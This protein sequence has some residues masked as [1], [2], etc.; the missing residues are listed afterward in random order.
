[1]KTIISTVSIAVSLI[2]LLFG[3]ALAGPAIHYDQ[4]ITGEND[5]TKDV[6]AVQT[7]VDLGGKILLKGKFN[8]GPGRVLIKNM[9]DGSV[10]EVQIYGETDRKSNPLTKITGGFWS[11]LSPLPPTITGPGPKITISGI[12]FQG[13]IWAPI[14][15]AYS[16]EIN[17]SGNKIS[18]VVSY[19][20]GVFDP[21]YPFFNY[22]N[23]GIICGPFFLLPPP[24]RVYREGAVTGILKIQNNFIDLSNDYPGNTMGQGIFV[25]WTTGITAHIS[26]NIIQNVPRNSIEVLDNYLANGVGSII[27]EGNE[28][29]TS[30]VGLPYPSE[31]TPNGIVFGWYLNPAGYDKANNCL[32]TVVR[33]SIRTKGE[34]SVGITALADGSVVLNNHIVSEGAAARGLGVVGSHGIFAHNKIEGRGDYA[35]NVEPTPTNSLLKL[36]ASYNFFQGNNLNHFDAAEFDLHFADGADHNVFVGHSGSVWDEGKDNR[37]TNFNYRGKGLKLGSK[38]KYFLSG[39]Q[40]R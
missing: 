18:D 26:N 7:A 31:F 35:I 27:M 8:F 23:A 38:S 22:L 30:P 15:I 13:S 11:F 28:I 19:G 21:A 37:I 24:A 12:H 20:P 34:T 10:N 14:Y 6:I 25:N 36:D 4:T 3:Q 32:H 33:N 39:K 9:P 16:S 1:M 2:L 40:G 17:I 29:E 5:A